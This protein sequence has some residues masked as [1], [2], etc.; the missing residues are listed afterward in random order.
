MRK[1][2]ILL[3]AVILMFTSHLMAGMPDYDTVEGGW[4]DGFMGSWGCREW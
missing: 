4:C 2:G 1:F 3:G